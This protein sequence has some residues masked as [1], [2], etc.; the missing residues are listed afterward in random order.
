MENNSITI[1]FMILF[2]LFFVLTVDVPDGGDLLDA[3]ITS[4]KE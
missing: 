2:F 1:T 4:T 3:I